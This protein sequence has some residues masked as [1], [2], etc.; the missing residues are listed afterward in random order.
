MLLYRIFRNERKKRLKLAH[1]SVM[2]T[3]FVLACCGLRAVFNFHNGAG[4][5]NMYSLHSWLGILTVVL[6]IAQVM[7]TCLIW[8]I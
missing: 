3:A 1:A 7:I 5:N 2:I 4:I 8:L 6:F